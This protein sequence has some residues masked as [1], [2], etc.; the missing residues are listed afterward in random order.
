M[1]SSSKNY[2]FGINE[3]KIFALDLENL[4]DSDWKIE[5]IY[6]D[7]DRDFGGISIE[8]HIVVTASH[9]SG[10][11]YYTNI[12]QRIIVYDTNETARYNY[13]QQ[14]EWIF[15]LNRGVPLSQQ[16]VSYKDIIL[17]SDLTLN[18]DEYHLACLDSIFSME[19]GVFFLF[20]NYVI[21][22]DV[23]LTRNGI[24]YLSKVEFFNLIREINNLIEINS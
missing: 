4:L 11:S 23:Y 6:I 9:K 7:E 17:P 10:S 15:T 24:E 12:K 2:S 21:Y 20:D 16:I 14:V 19:C 8:G 3:L 13:S 22:L 1:R 5:E 18:V